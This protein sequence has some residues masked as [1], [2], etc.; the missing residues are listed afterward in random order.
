MLDI[1]LADR[2]L[3]QDD[4]HAAMQTL[5]CFTLWTASVHLIICKSSVCSK[6]VKSGVHFQIFQHATICVTKTKMVCSGPFSRSQFFGKG[7]SL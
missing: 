2:V 4:F 6:S 5:C 1:I 7:P 3:Q